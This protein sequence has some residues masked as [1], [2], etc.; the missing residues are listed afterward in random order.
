LVTFWHEPNAEL[1]DGTFTIAQFK[2][3]TIRLS[4]RLVALGI[5]D[6]WIIAPNFTGP[7]PQVGNAWS[8]TWMMTPDQLHPGARW[9]W[10]VYGNLYGGLA[11]DSPYRPI[12]EVLD[13]TFLRTQNFGWWANWGITEFNTPRRNFDLDE[14]QRVQWLD[15][16][17]RYCLAA[18][19]PPKSMLLWEGFGVQFDQFFKT[20][21][22]K[23]WWRD[24]TARSI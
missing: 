2:A 20:S 4:N 7:Y 16:F 24:V 11:Y 6:K 17:V 21:R 9:T 19:G 8:D 10:D 15:D 14:A 12:P 13:P 5:T 3:A 23:D 1:R 18:P 22:T